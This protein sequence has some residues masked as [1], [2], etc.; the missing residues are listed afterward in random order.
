MVSE[1]QPGQTFFR[2]SAARP[3]AHPDTMGENNTPCGVK[4]G[5]FCNILQ[6]QAG[7]L[8]ITVGKTTSICTLP[9]STKCCLIMSW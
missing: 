7:R 4:T 3:P 5:L 1:I 6:R 2:R 9:T 8:T